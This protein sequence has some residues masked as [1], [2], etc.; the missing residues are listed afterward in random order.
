MTRFLASRFGVLVAL[1]AVALLMTA[2]STRGIS[3]PAAGRSSSIALT[4]DDTTLVNVNSD[5]PYG[6]GLQ[7]DNRATREGCRDSRWYRSNSVAIHPTLGKAYVADAY[8]GT[9]SVV[10]LS[11]LKVTKTIAVGAEPMGVAVSPNGTRLYVANSS[12]NSVTVID[13]STEAIVA[14]VGV[15]AF[16]TAPRAL[17]VTGNGDA[18]DADETVFVAL[19]FGQ[20]RGGKTSDRGGSGERA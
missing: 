13:T 7:R 12:S 5:V 8:S 1:C 4:I 19:F 11:L 6:F 2:R 17:A 10:D 9:V 20:L 3:A 16:G 15:S 14:T 18:S